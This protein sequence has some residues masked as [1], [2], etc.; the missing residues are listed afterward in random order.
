MKFGDKVE[1]AHYQIEFSGIEYLAGKNYL[2]RQ[3]KFLITRNNQNITILK[4]QSRYYPESDQ[5]TTEADIKHFIFADLYLVMGG[6]DELENYVVRIYYK[7]LISFIYLGCVLI[8]CGGIISI[9]NGL[10]ALRRLSKFN[11]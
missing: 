4:P 1:I 9:E 8:F 2:A 10:R 6:K 3:G 7:P 11:H 5:T